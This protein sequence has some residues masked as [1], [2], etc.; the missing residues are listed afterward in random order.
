MAHALNRSLLCNFF[1]LLLGVELPLPAFEFPAKSAFFK[2]PLLLFDDFFDESELEELFKLELAVL[3][4]TW[5]P[6]LLDES[7]ES[8][9]LLLLVEPLLLFDEFFDDD[10][11][12]FVAELT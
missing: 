12:W 9:E 11:D 1:V 6:C 3:L 10:L 4:L 8:E 2:I 5:T 7:F